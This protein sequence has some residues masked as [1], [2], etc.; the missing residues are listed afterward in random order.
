MLT[1]EHHQRLDDKKAKFGFGSQ[2]DSGWMV[3]NE[4]WTKGVDYFLPWLVCKLKA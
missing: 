4:E 1:A 3:I 2:D